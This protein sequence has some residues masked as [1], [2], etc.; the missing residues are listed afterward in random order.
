MRDYSSKDVDAYIAQAPSEARLIMSE[1]RN[2]IE[3]ALPDT[4]EETISWGVPFYK[5]HGPVAGFS[6][7]K[8]HVSFGF[9]AL[10]DSSMRAELESRGYATGTKTLQI[11][12]DQKIPDRIVIRLIK[13]QVKTNELKKK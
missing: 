10:L 13:S 8:K 9:N 11:K 7:F 12:F 4:A 2:V 1:L 5:Y 3:S 6:F